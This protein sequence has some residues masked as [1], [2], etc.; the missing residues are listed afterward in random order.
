MLILIQV[1]SKIGI[2]D[3]EPSEEFLL[4][5]YPTEHSCSDTFR[6]LGNLAARFQNDGNG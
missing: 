6:T 4:E 3:Y 1:H 2:H 5:E